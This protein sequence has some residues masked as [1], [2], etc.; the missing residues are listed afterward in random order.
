MND[1]YGILILGLFDLK[2][3]NCVGRGGGRAN[4]LKFY[5][6]FSSVYAKKKN[7]FFLHHWRCV[8]SVK[9]KYRAVQA[10]LK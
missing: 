2:Y 4:P 8:P 1:S 3:H 6:F 5:L 9:I 10:D 7:Y